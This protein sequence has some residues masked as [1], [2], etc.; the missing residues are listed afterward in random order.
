MTQNYQKLGLAL[1]GGA[2]YG[3]AH[4]G[5]LKAMEEL[6]INPE[7]VSGTSIGAFVA[8]FYAFGIPLDKIESIGTN[9]DWLDISGLKLSKLGLLSNERLGEVVLNNL[10][11]VRIEE[12][13]IPL[14]II[15][16]DICSGEKIAMTSGSLS[17][18][19]MASVCIP[20]L[21]VPVNMGDKLLVDGGLC[22]NVP[23]QTVRAM[24]AEEVIAVDLT[25]NR[26]YKCPDD[27]IDVLTT[28][29]DIGLNNLINEQI[30]GEKTLLIQPELTA[31]NRADIEKSSELIDKGYDAAMAV[32]K[33]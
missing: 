28:S 23:L 3:A 11:D 22:E 24:G 15:A 4:I 20:G 21:F 30:E 1:G 25:T 13:K 18:A 10:G 19:I 6:E 2:A 27:I 31:Y 7:F 5:V 16:T 29:F 33:S 14:S 12:S 17:Q 26:S 32:L 9:L 8:A